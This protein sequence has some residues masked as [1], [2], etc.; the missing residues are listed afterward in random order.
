MLCLCRNPKEV[1]SNIGEQIP[2]QQIDELASELESKQAKSE[3]FVFHVL[4]SGL[5]PEGT[6]PTLKMSFYSNNLKRKSLT[7]MSVPGILLVDS[8]CS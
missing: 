1:G 7:G 5:P 6:T 2:Q 3:I 8:R 4:L